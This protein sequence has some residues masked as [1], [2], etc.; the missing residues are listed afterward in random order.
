MG[1]E[2]FIM[3]R[4]EKWEL[5]PN[6]NLDVMHAYNKMHDGYKVQVE[7]GIVQ[8]LKKKWKRFMKRFDSTKPRYSHLII[9]KT[10]LINFPLKRRMDLTYK[11]F[12]DH[13][14]NLEDHGWVG[15]F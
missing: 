5:V 7:W 9:S 11:V 8:R 4:I 14:L 2:M 12:G 13:L 6:V 15:D 10:L 1:E 3:R